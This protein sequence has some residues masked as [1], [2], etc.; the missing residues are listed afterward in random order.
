MVRLEGTVDGEHEVLGLGL[1]TVVSSARGRQGGGR[2]G[3]M[4][5]SFTLS[6]WRWARATSSSSAL[7]RMWTPRGYEAESVKRAICASTWLVNE[8][9]MTHEG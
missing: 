1:D 6:E 9:D 4:T 5:E 7:G 2:T 8:Q 3:V